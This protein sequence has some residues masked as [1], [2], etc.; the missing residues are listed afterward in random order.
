MLSKDRAAL[1]RNMR[2]AFADA[3]PT[4]PFY[5]ANDSYEPDESTTWAAFAFNPDEATRHTISTPT[6]WKQVG[7]ATLQIMQPKNLL[8]GEGEHDA[9]D[10]ADIGMTAF[11]GW[12]SDDKLTEI[13]HFSTQRIP[14]DHYVQLNLLI[15]WRSKRP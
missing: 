1:N 12:R 14:N 11:K 9:W 5:L 7:I 13:S 3:A 2:L 4:L 15:F 10:I 6:I 8:I